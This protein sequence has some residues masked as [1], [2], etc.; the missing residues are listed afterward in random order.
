VR[1]IDPALL[2][3]GD[4]K[5]GKPS[6][7]SESY[8]THVEKV[9]VDAGCEIGPQR[10]HPHMHILLTVKEALG[11]YAYIILFLERRNR[12][13]E[14]TQNNRRKRRGGSGDSVPSKAASR[15]SAGSTQST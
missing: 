9:S 12:T 13:C 11:T 4:G 14:H 10:K 6:Y 3:Y 8:E 1:P 2:F 15:I 5:G 7:I